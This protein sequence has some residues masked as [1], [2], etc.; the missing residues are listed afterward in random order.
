MERGFLSTLLT[1]VLSEKPNGSGDMQEVFAPIRSKLALARANEAIGLG[2]QDEVI[3]VRHSR[4]FFHPLPC[5]IQTLCRF[6]ED[7]LLAPKF[8][9]DFIS[10]T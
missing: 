9:E 5:N 3:P 2:I 1:I 6:N 7:D 8:L 10:L 4:Q